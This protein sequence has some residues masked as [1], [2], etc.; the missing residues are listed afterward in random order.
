VN[1]FKEKCAACGICRKVCPFLSEFGTPE[2]ILAGCPE[3]SFYCTSCGRC[4]TVCPLHLSPSDAF[5]AAKERLVRERQM[6]LPVGTALEGAR[7]FAKAGHGFP[8]SFYGSAETVFWPG[9]TLAG[10]EPGLVREL[11]AILGGRLHRKVGLALDCCYDPVYGLGDLQTAYAALQNINQRLHD[12]GVRQVIT[13]CLNCHKLLTRHLKDIEVIFIMELLPTELFEKKWAGAAYLH[14]PC[15]SARREDIRINAQEIFS[16]LQPP[17]EDKKSASSGPSEARCCGAGGGLSATWP[18]LADCFLDQIVRE[19]KGAT[20]VT[21]CAGCRNRFL[22]RGA[23]A[24]HLLEGLSRKVPRGKVLSSPVQWANRF[25]LS[26]TARL[27]TLKFLMAILMVLLISGGVYL[28]QQN[29]FSAAALTALLGRY[30]VAAPLIFLCIYAVA[31]SLFL[32]AIPLTLAAGFFWGPVWGVIFAISGAT[33]GSCLP[34]FL[35]RYLLQDT[36]KSRVAEERWNWLQDKVTEHGWKAVAFT[37]L[38]PV[39]PFNLLNYLFGLT[40]IP[41]RHYLWST[42]VFMLPACIAFVAFGSSLGELIL[43]GNVRGLV[44]GIAVA[45]CAFLIPVL[46]RPF[47]RKIGES[48]D[49][50]PGGN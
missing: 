34:F 22:T 28:T 35:S 5:F 10:S 39:F 24:V 18:I 19:A 6:P 11:C 30:P 9:C 14:H 20:L 36:V 38:I 49:Q 44:I 3:V 50:T 17:P 33:I 15:A 32:P 29:V 25:L 8:F 40:P 43:R 45:V 13:G 21:Y 48:K 7:A 31:P 2:E 41:F 27:K 23:K 46:I 42:F 47:F 26:M 37:R 4:E 16:H 1:D 12:H